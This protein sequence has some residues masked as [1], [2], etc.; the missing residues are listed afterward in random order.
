MKSERKTHKIFDSRLFWNCTTEVFLS[1]KNE[2]R[3]RETTIVCDI[4]FCTRKIISIYT[5]RFTKSRMKRKIA[6]EKYSLFYQMATHIWRTHI[7]ISKDL[8]FFWYKAQC[9]LYLWQ[10]CV[11]VYNNEMEM[12]KGRERYNACHVGVAQNDYT[13]IFAFSLTL[14]LYYLC[15]IS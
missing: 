15:V 5:L 2:P 8:H 10:W 13:G 6:R 4:V 7:H 1:L 12:Q 11:G 3:W 9:F 14:F